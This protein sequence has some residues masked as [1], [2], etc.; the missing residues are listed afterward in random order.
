GEATV[1]NLSVD[2]L[3]GDLL[4]SSSEGKDIQIVEY[5]NSGLS[6]SEQVHWAIQDG[7]LFIQDGRGGF[8]CTSR[9]WND[10]RVEVKLPHALAQ[11]LSIVTIGCASGNV[12]V[13]NLTCAAL[14][15]SIASGDVKLEQVTTSESRLDAASGKIAA[16]GLD[17]STLSIALTSGEITVS[18]S[19]QSI[20]LDVTSGS[21]IV[22][23]AVAPQQVSVDL[24]SGD[25]TILIPEGKGFTAEVDKLSGTFNCSFVTTN[26][27]PH[28]YVFKDGT[29][30][31]RFDITSGTVNLQKA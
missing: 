31:Y 7:T 26:T 5:S 13:S 21:A 27:T 8:G 24:T 15:T 18:G 11:G 20:D 28:T 1:E 3:N 14:T 12:R 22:R 25:A 30:P 19:Y 23:S 17:A 2:W 10:Q 9:I 16:T 4:I 29:A 6:T